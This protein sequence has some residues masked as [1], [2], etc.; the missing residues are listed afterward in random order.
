MYSVFHCAARSTNSEYP[1]TQVD[2]HH[3]TLRIVLAPRRL[4]MGKRLLNCWEEILQT[5]VQ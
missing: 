4:A 3:L 2:D 5:D 1:I